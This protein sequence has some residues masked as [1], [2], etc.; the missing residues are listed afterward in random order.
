MR[1]VNTRVVWFI[2]LGSFLMSLISSCSDSV[3]QALKSR[4]SVRGAEANKEPTSDSTDDLVQCSGVNR[5]ITLENSGLVIQMKNLNQL[6]SSIASCLG[7]DKLDI[8]SSMI[9]TG[10]V[11]EKDGQI[12]FLGSSD[13]KVG[14]DILDAESKSLVDLEYGQRSTIVGD[15]ATATY[16]RSLA[17]VADVVAHNCTPDDPKCKC[18]TR[19]DAN[20]MLNRCVPALDP[21]SEGFKAGVEMMYYV[22]AENA[23]GMRKAV[24]SL[25]SSYAFGMAR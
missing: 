12:R 20:A 18:A 3:N 24:S 6:R 10:T 5:S 25:I 15:G 7:Q 11:P 8:S 13:F 22:C 19:E 14:E 21:N 16:L 23:F 1:S 9:S 4:S 2:T 17:L